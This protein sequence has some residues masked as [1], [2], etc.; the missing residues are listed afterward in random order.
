LRSAVGDG[1]GAEALVGARPLVALSPV[2]FRLVW[3]K[4]L[5]QQKHNDAIELHTQRF[6]IA[7]AVGQA[8][9]ERLVTVHTTDDIH[10]PTVPR[11]V[12][13]DVVKIS[14]S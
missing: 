13:P 8:K 4:C 1:G 5:I 7:F 11:G 3:V 14:F 10:A 9:N 12:K 2:W 6:K